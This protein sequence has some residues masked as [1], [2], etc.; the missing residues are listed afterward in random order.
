MAQMAQTL[1]QLPFNSILGEIFAQICGTEV[2]SVVIGFL[3]F[4]VVQTRFLSHWGPTA[5]KASK[6]VAKTA[7]LNEKT[8]DNLE[9]VPASPPPTTTTPG[10]TAC[11]Q[12][13]R[14]MESFF[15]QRTQQ[16]QDHIQNF[17]PKEATSADIKSVSSDPPKTSSFFGDRQQQRQGHIQNFRPPAQS[18][19]RHSNL[20]PTGPPP[21]LEQMSEAA[22]PDRRV[23]TTD[24]RRSD[25]RTPATLATTI[26]TKSSVDPLIESLGCTGLNGNEE[27]LMQLWTDVMS[28]PMKDAT[29]SVAIGT[30]SS[31]TMTNRRTRARP[32][33]GKRF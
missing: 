4:Y 27:A 2:A 18:L 5:R 8:C 17:R 6:L 3:I 10:S 25:R 31:T 26:A 33:E 9:S 32:N 13:T 20:G 7:E 28:V 22:V 21:G 29:T 24:G 16:R 1:G 15:A 11:N 23:P 14:K 30:H 19:A 12:K